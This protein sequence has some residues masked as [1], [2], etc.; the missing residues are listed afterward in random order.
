MTEYNNILVPTDFSEPSDQAVHTA[1]ELARRFKAEL[2]ILHVMAPRIHYVETPEVMLPPL[3][4]FTEDLRAANHEKLE[5]LAKEAGAKLQV[6]T[7]LEES[8]EHTAGTICAFARRLP[9]DL[10]VIGSH[11][12]TGLLHI[13]LGST[14]ER[15]VREA[16]CP[17]LV[18]K[19]TTEEEQE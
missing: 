3:E 14:A 1:T 12:H 6:H 16:H 15:V 18:T 13:L 7:Y 5:A 4:D 19:P 10:I 2:H 9:A 17:V 11:G 8:S